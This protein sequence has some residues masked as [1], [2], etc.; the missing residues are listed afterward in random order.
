MIVTVKIS[1]G[2]STMTGGHVQTCPWMVLW[3]RRRK[4]HW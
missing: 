4:Y 1:A 2:N 3:I